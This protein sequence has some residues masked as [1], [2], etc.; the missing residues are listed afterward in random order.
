MTTIRLPFSPRVSL[1]ASLLLGMVP[2]LHGSAF[3]D[4]EAGFPVMR[5]FRP[6]DYGGHPQVHAVIESPK[7]TILLGNANGMMEY[8]GTRWTHV[9]APVPNLMQLSA[10]AD[11]RVYGG[12]DDNFGYFELDEQGEWAYRSLMEFFPT[13]AGPLRRVTSIISTPEGTLVLNRT[14]AFLWDGRTIRHL[15][16]WGDSPSA[17]ELEGT[18]YLLV[19]DRGLCRWQDGGL[20]TVSSDPAFH[21]PVTFLPARLQDGRLLIFLGAGGT[22]TVNEA[23]GE[24]QPHPTPADPILEQTRFEDIIRI[25]GIGWAITTFG[26]GVL[27]LSPD[28]AKMRILDRQ[29]G[30]FDD[31]TLDLYLDREGGLWIGYNT[32]V[33]RVQIQGGTSIFDGRNGPPP[34][35]VDSWGRFGGRLFVGCF[36][37][38]WEMIPADPVAGTSARFER[39]DFGIR[40]VFFIQEH[41]G[42]YLFTSRRHLCR[43]EPGAG[44]EPDRVVTLLD[45]EGTIPFKASFSQLYPNRLYIP[46]LSGFAVAEKHNGEWTLLLNNQELGYTRQLIENPDGTLWLSSYTIGFVHVQPPASG[47]WKEAV[48]TTY[49]QGHGLPDDI[50]WTEVYADEDGP[51]FFTDKGSRRWD[52]QAKLFVADFRYRDAFGGEVSFRPVIP[53]RTG[54]TFGSRYIG[55]VREAETPLGA[56]RHDGKDGMSWHP[57]SPGV[58]EEIGFAGVAEMHLERDSEREILWSRG[59][60]HMVRMDLSEP[61]PPAIP[62]QTTVHRISGSQPPLEVGPDGALT[63][64]YS[65]EPIQ[66]ELAAPQFSRGQAIQFQHRLIGFNER[67][68]DPIDSPLVSFTNLEGGPFTFEARAIDLAGQVS[69]PV[70]LRFAV[71]PPWHRSRAAYALYGLAALGLAG[72]FM[73]WRLGA[74]RAEQQRLSKLVGERT[75]ELQAATEEARSAN[76]AKS[77][78]LANMSHELR[79]PLNGILGYTQVLRRDREMPDTVRERIQIIEE[80]GNHLLSMINEVLDISKIEARRMELADAPFPLRQL[81]DQLAAS[82]ELRATAKGLAFRASFDRK[83]PDQA[84]ADGRKLRQI[85]E[86]LLNNAIKFTNSGSVTFSASMDTGWLKVEVSDTGPGIPL[87][88]QPTIFEPFTH[89]AANQPA[90][91]ESS[92]GLGLPLAKAYAELMGGRIGL[93]SDAGAGATFMVTVPIDSVDAVSVLTASTES[94]YSGYEGVR[95]RLLVVDD[96]PLNRNIL[97]DLLLPLGFIIEEAAS[98]GETLERLHRSP[99]DGLLLDLRLPDGNALDSVPLMRRQFPHLPI[100]A[101]SAS[102]LDLSTEDILRAGCSAFL[103]KPFKLDQLLELLGQFLSLQW[104]ESGSARSA[105]SRT[106]MPDLASLSLSPENLERLMAMARSGDV[107]AMRHLLQSLSSEGGDG[108]RL[109]ALLE[110]ALSRYQMGE[111]RRLLRLLAQ[112]SSNQLSDETDLHHSGR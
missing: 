83:L 46:T 24:L 88:D 59:Y 50:V 8:D 11:G 33:G 91:G 41:D 66:I 30:L 5:Q 29:L 73:R 19:R 36:D 107:F 7:G 79:T 72:G 57:A 85:L 80:S 63:F 74:A 4:P 22:W 55:L 62:W 16:D 49:K 45:L 94:D 31:V 97:R 100:I 77:R 82:A 52:N 13:D 103:G 86:N 69:D 28:A 68:S 48:F 32:G 99:P 87:K 6:V 98:V 35:T 21:S 26:R 101:I 58:L 25:P 67:W 56:Y 104:I 39:R 51:Y 27:V 102:V 92:T 89:V 10:G 15:Q 53:T 71:R 70:R 17:W 38:L 12:G 96:L 47:D 42:E 64:A 106:D 23:T 108:P 14:K 61:V 78:F 40:N 34:G 44:G 84:L 1:L 18:V 2:G 76:A 90:P 3:F 75:R 81:L 95:R 93:T 110:P 60:H 43:L 65:R 105:Q 54:A 37:G 20:V 111:V 9:P 109:R 112:S